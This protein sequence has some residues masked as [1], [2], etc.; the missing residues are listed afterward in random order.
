MNR[1][2]A[3]L[4]CSVFGIVLGTLPASAADWQYP[5][6]VAVATDGTIYIADRNLPGIWT[7]KDGK[8]EVFVQA[9]NAEVDANRR[10]Q[11]QLQAMAAFD[12]LRRDVHCAGSA[13]AGGGTITLSGCAAGDVT[14]CVVGS[15]TRYALYRQLGSTCDSSGRF[16]AD[17]LTSASP[18]AYTPPV[19]ATSLAKVRADITVNVN[20]AEAF[21]FSGTV[22]ESG[23]SQHTFDV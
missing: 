1:P 10:V 13:T 20:G 23:E 11:A 5:I 4:C 21:T 2:T 9:S 17:Y 18:F 3:F 7:L 12:R 22:S 19:A 15:G 16:Y 8:T 14:W 6:D